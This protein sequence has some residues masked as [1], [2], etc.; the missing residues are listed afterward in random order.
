M[1]SWLQKNEQLM[2]FTIDWEIMKKQHA[3]F[4][5]CY[6][7][8]SP[9]KN[10]ETTT[11]PHLI[12]VSVAMTNWV[13]DPPSSCPWWQVCGPKI[14]RKNMEE[15]WKTYLPTNHNIFLKRWF[16]PPI[17]YLSMHGTM[18]ISSVFCRNET[19]GGQTQLGI[20]TKC[21]QQQAAFF[22]FE[23]MILLFTGLGMPGSPN[24]EVC[25]KKDALNRFARLEVL[26]L[27]ISRLASR[28]LCIRHL[29]KDLCIFRAFCHIKAP[30]LHQMM[31]FSPRQRLAGIKLHEVHLTL[32][33]AT[34]RIE[35]LAHTLAGGDPSGAQR[36]PKDL[37]LIGLTVGEVYIIDIPA[38]L[39]AKLLND[40][41]KGPVGWNCHHH[42]SNHI[43]PIVKGAY[44][45]LHGQ[46][47]VSKPRIHPHRILPTKR[48]FCA[49]EL[50]VLGEPFV[51]DNIP[52]KAPVPHVRPVG[53]EERH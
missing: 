28:Q 24:S 39:L 44:G 33:E 25:V 46:S 11:S 52:A 49:L 1:S 50:L 2:I 42:T 48:V 32:L 4:Q 3:A 22:Q 30:E 19:L 43:V 27:H 6:K 37:V 34:N 31:V 9:E 45:L 21:L 15:Q 5:V 53:Q 17:Q 8:R 18:L 16:F 10:I 35:G 47:K 20:L 7:A 23:P 51:V 13:L 12:D 40:G 26:D 38:I 41:D 29:T 14:A 36:K